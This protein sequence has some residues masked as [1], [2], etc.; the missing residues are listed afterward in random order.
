MFRSFC[1]EDIAKKRECAEYIRFV[2]AS[3]SSGSTP[4]A[5]ALAGKPESKPEELFRRLAR[6]QKRFS[7][8]VFGHR[9]ATLCVKKAF[10][11]FTDQ[12]EIHLF[13]SGQF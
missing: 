10:G 5:V 3:H 12:N 2:D 13:S 9:A 6:D 7:R 1:I 4:R 11:A 8:F